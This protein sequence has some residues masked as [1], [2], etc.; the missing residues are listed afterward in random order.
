MQK[1]KRSILSI[2]FIVLIAVAVIQP[3]PYVI[4]TPGPVFNTLGE[5]NGTPYVDIS[6]VKT[7]PT[8]GELNMTT[9][10]IYGGPDKGVDLFQAINAIFPWNK[11]NHVVPRQVIFPEDMTASENAAI[12]A[13]EFSTSQSYAIAAAMKYLHRH[14]NEQI[15]V[16]SVQQGMPAEK[17]LKAGDV[18]VAVDGKKAV[19]PEQTVNLI[20][21]PPAGRIVKLTIL[22]DSVLQ[23][24]KIKTVPKPGSPKLPYIGIGID[25][26]YSADFPIEFGVNDVGGPSAGTMFAL[27][28]IDQLTPGSLTGGK[29]VAGTGTID[30]DGQVGP[31]GGIQQKM[32]A[33]HDHGAKLFIAPQDNCDDVVGNTPAG[34]TVVPVRTLSDAVQ[35]LDDF[36]IGK[37]L[38]AC[39]VTTP[40]K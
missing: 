34:L 35:V 15:V 10:S 2:A 33:A 14:V 5:S 25:T 18:I 20:R 38:S 30:P 7:Y 36:R 37:P 12:N 3:V 32:F 6:G 1:R 21:V 27:S 23:N 8:S 29:I 39:K 22:R 11:R 28:V 16:N 19:T 31:I 17:Y 13:S 24:Y 40:K 26:L 9:V 4:E